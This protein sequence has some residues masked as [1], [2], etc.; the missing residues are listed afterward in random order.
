[1]VKVRIIYSSDE[2]KRKLINIFRDYYKILNVSK[3]YKKEGT[4]KRMHLDLINK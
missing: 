2:E 3:E 1:M 4:Y